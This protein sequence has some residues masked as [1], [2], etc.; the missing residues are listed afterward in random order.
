VPAL[1]APAAGASMRQESVFQDDQVLMRSGAERQAAGLAE[2]AAL[3][4]DT[5][6][7]NA[8]RPS[9]ELDGLVQGAQALGL[10]VMITAVGAA[11]RPSVRRY[12]RAVRALGA[13]YP[14]VHRWGLWNEP[15]Q[16]VWLW[17]QYARRGGRLVNVA[18]LRY[19]RLALAGTRALRATGHGSDVILLGETAPVGRTSGPPARRNAPP[20]F[21]LRAL[22]SGGPRLNVTGFAHHP[23]TQGA[24]SPPGERPSPGQIS[25]TNVRVLKRLLARGA[26]RGTIPARLPIWYTEFGYQTDP[27][28][29]RLGVSPALQA[30]YLNQAD[31][32]AAADPRIRAV[33]QYLL[34]DDRD[35]FGF[36]TGLRRFGSLAR[37]P[38]Y[39]AYRLPL[40]V[41][42]D[43][44]QV[45][46][47][48]QVRPAG[49]ADTVTIQHATTASGPYAAVRELDVSPPTHQFRARVA[50]APGVYRLAWEAPDGRTLVSRATG[51]G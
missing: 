25:F 12:R 24:H 17:P 33:S 28:D 10:D 19:R 47:Y 21:F 32:I 34:V 15:N 43:G 39:G 51:P 7:V 9:A 40:W 3:G 4:A 45:R 41:R 30:A 38:A 49:G 46:I 23:Y 13:R 44:G 48:G 1:L 22:L 20:A 11:R 8:R 6:R 5:V 36:Q 26:R 37:K 31:A 29:P 14:G 2:I 42:R 27:P 18:A 16:A 50:Y 35:V